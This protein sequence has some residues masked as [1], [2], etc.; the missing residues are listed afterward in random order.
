M[1]ALQLPCSPEHLDDVLAAAHVDSARVMRTDAPGQLA[2]IDQVA[3]KLRA[4]ITA[5]GVNLAVPAEAR[6]FQLG[7]LF[8]GCSL[9]NNQ[10]LHA[11]QVTHALV[12][13]AARAAQGTPPRVAP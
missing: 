3:A 7:V 2:N 11:G 8:V 13:Y 10:G 9:A 6:A 5:L 4:S 12:A 1:A